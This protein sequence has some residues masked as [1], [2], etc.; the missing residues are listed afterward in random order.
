MSTVLAVVAHPD[1]E[2][3]GAGGTLARH[4]AA[5]DDVHVLVLGDGVTSR[6]DERTPA[7]EAE[8][9]RRRER[10]RSAADTLGVD[11][12]TFEDFPDN[13]FDSIPLLELTQR[14]ETAL[15]RHAPEMLYT[16]HYGDLSADHVRRYRRHAGDEGGGDGGVR[17]RGARFATPSV[18]RR[19]GGERPLVGTQER[20][21]RRRGVRTAPRATLGF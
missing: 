15:D 2:T 11:S 8:I 10:A 3:I 20:H 4:A 17:R 21:G 16:H 9:E 19:P 14:V 1:D 18:R 6:Y 13:A 5:G 12:I 7:A